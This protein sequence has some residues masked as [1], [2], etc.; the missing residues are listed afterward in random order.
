[1]AIDWSL[2]NPDIK[3]EIQKL[4]D[5]LAGV[6]DALERAGL[7]KDDS[8][9]HDLNQEAYITELTKRTFVDKQQLC[10]IF[11]IDDNTTF[12]RWKKKLK[13]IP[14]GN[15]TIYLMEDLQRLEEYKSIYKK[16]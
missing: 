16:K 3:A 8:T 4:R 2:M 7:Y 9:L 15:T 11:G 13:P 5:D 12:Y 1:M 10:L 6:L 14:T